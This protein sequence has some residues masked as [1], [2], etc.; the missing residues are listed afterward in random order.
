MKYTG[1]KVRLSRRLGIALTP[2]AA[3]V[4]QKKPHGPGQPPRGRRMRKS[5]D[6]SRQLLEKQRLRFSYNVHERQMRT[7]YERAS[8]RGG[9]TIDNMIHELESRL[10]AV[11]LRSGLARTIYAAR[12]V[13]NHGHVTVNGK[14]VNIPS[15][16][17]RPNDV[18]SVKEKSRKIPGFREALSSAKAPPYLTVDV[19]NMTATLLKLPDRSEVPVICDMAQV[20]AFYSR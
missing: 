2:R 11:V 13:V 3:R 18:V 4:M 1:P 9:N 14:S 17:L 5:S 16:Q 12:Q 6:Y 20:I 19:N 15:Y 7:Y 8:R 10:D